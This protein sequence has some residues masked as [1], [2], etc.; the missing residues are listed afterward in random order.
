LFKLTIISFTRKFRAD[1]SKKKDVFKT[2]FTFFEVMI[3]VVILAVGVVSVYRAFFASLNYQK[4]LKARLYAE[5]FLHD[6][7]TVIQQDY[8][9]SKE[10]PKMFTAVPH[11]VRLDNEPI[12]FFCDSHYL[13]LGSLEDI[14]QLELVL[15]WRQSGRNYQIKKMTYLSRL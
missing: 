9:R 8:Q 5:E 6:Q 11:T 15:S 13:T 3:T 14:L 12:E 10:E 4:Y 1:P 2:G 7:I